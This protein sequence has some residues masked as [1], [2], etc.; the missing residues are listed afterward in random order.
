MIDAAIPLQVQSPAPISPIG[1]V[2]QLMGIRDMASQ[3]ALRNAQTQQ[4]QQHSEAL[5]AEAQKRQR[6]LQGQQDLQRMYQD[7]NTA[8]EFGAGRFESA[9]G[10][11]PSEVIDDERKR[12]QESILKFSNIDT[13]EL[14]NRK[15]HAENIAR[16]L[17]SLLSPE[18]PEDKIPEYSASLLANLRNNGDLKYVSIPIPERFN[19]REEVRR[20]APAANV[21]QSIIDA[22]IKEQEARLKPA[23]TQAKI[24][25][26][27]ANA[28]LHGTEA[29]M[30]GKEL[31]GYNE[32]GQS[33]TLQVQE[34]ENIAKQKM[35]EAELGRQIRADSEHQRH[36]LSE[37][38]IS[39]MSAGVAAGHLAQVQLVNGMKYGPGTTEY[40]VK[41]LQDNPDSIKEMPPELRST[42]GQGFTKSTGLPL[43]TPASAANQQQETAARNALDGA[44]FIQ[45]A[46]QNPEIQANL[47]PIMG[48]LGNTEQAIGTALHLSPEASRIAQELRTRMRYFVFQEGKAV[49]GGRL[50]QQLMG[51]LEESSPNVKM[52]P[53]MLQ[54][55]L[56]GAVGNAASVLENVDKQRFGGQSRSAATRRVAEIA[57]QSSAAPPLPARLS[58]SDIGKS[59]LNKDG[60]SITITDVNPSDPT[61]FRFK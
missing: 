44:T 33:P 24:D 46:L 11:I 52:D 19:T 15:T 20:Y 2:G 10:K 4:A 40:W 26:A 42:V 57:N 34:A 61:Q 13:A 29:Q 50:P 9:L 41:Q 17:S 3:V 45:K 59:F 23:E 27:K 36:N 56:N 53:S 28:Q 8:K 55:A 43:P 35:A 32:R 14:A 18:T 25:E 31:S 58:K 51:Q 38:S 5:A 21:Y 39:R 60:K 49:L 16:G 6:L 48:R 7:A 37:E 47:G 22:G 54:G 1:A 12:V 30:K